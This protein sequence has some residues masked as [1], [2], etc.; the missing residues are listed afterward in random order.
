[1]KRNF[2]GMNAKVALAVLAVCS[3]A[4]TSCYEKEEIDT[5]KPVPAPAAIYF[6]AGSITDLTTGE[7]ITPTT[8]TIT[9]A[10]ETA[11]PA[12]SFKVKAAANATVKVTVEKAGYYTASKTVFVGVAA[13]GTTNYINADIAMTSLN[14][15]PPTA[16]E[17]VATPDGSISAADLTTLGI[18]NNGAAV[19]F[20]DGKAT[21]TTEEVKALA[22]IFTAAYVPVSYTKIQDGV[23]I[24]KVEVT[25]AARAITSV[26][27]ATLAALGRAVAAKLNTPYL[28]EKFTTVS[29]MGEV[30]QAA[31]KAVLKLTVN[32]QYNSAKVDFV[33]NGKKHTV[34]YMSAAQ[35][36]LSFVYDT[37]DG[38]DGHG[39]AT[40]AGGGSGSSK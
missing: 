35:Q 23:I 22:P 4:L 32:T 20:K 26:D 8:L 17:A 12:T 34:S 10:T 16:G 39:G 28:G 18:P 9:G 37:H 19:E 11:T 33:F 15:T 14:T 29:A 36:G 2:F 27:A 38:H 1:M 6:V 5:T 7:A 31:G 40:N 24:T 21:V 3:T 13:D 25:N 30:W